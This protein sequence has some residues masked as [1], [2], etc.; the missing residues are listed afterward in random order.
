[1][2]QK[3]N[4]ESL[5]QQE[6]NDDELNTHFHTTTNK[7]IINKMKKSSSILQQAQVLWFACVLYD[8]VH[9]FMFAQTHLI[10]SEEFPF[11]YLLFVCVY[12]KF[13]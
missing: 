9:F 2:E 12:A 7:K 4:L 11:I 3:K 6:G 13:T 8:S 10:D 5:A 1:M